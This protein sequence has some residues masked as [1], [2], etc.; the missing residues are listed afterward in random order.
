MRLYTFAFAAV[1]F[2]TLDSHAQDEGRGR[3]L[4]DTHCISCHTTRVYSRPDRKA[5][6]Y[7]QV[8][9][10]VDRWQK[11][12]SLNWQDAEI[13]LVTEYIATRF[14]RYDCPTKC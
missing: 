9:D 6:D 5:G 11:N 10:Q 13:E 7:Q 3:L 14:Y 8:R 2:V 12:V 4:H 1:L